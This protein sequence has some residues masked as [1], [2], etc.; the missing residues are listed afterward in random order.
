[1]VLYDVVMTKKAESQ[2]QE[3]V[4]YIVYTLLNDDA[5][6]SVL[7]DAR[8]TREALSKVA[9]SLRYCDHPELRKREIRSIFFRKHQYVMLYRIEG[10]TVFVEAVYHQ[11]QDY[12][13]IF[14]NTYKRR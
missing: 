12:E 5:A 11:K 4:D 2:L 3:Y 10:T 1:M 6:K 9:S 13:N 14:S 7:A 8:E